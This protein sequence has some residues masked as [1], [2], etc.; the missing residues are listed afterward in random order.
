MPSE[1]I[2]ITHSQVIFQSL[3]YFEHHKIVMEAILGHFLVLAEA[4][5]DDGSLPQ[6]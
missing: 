5:K 3:L 1:Y 2:N 6:P 4:F